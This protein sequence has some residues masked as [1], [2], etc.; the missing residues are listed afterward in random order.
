[1]ACFIGLLLS[2]SNTYGYFQCDRE[3]SKKIKGFFADKAKKGA[4]SVA[5]GI[6]K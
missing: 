5:S 3:Q 1:M 4:L 2:G 6:L